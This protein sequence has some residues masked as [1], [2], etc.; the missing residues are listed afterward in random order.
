MA[1]RQ[2]PTVKAK[3]TCYQMHHD[4]DQQQAEATDR[5]MRCGIMAK[6]HPAKPKTPSIAQLRKLAKEKGQTIT[7]EDGVL[8]LV[9]QGTWWLKLV[10]GPLNILTGGTIVRDER[11]AKRVLAAA[12]RALP[13]KEGPRG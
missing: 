5:C 4:C 13:D 12:L 3:A 7:E 10:H 6:N 8:K 11:D 1:K 2:S 9:E